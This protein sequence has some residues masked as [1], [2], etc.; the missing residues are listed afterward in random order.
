MNLAAVTIGR[1]VNAARR[2]RANAYAPYSRFAVGAAALAADGRIFSG[3][4]VENA[5]FG[6]T[7]CA[8]RNALA[9]MVAAGQRP[10]A[11]AIVTADGRATPCGACRQVLAE[12]APDLPII[13]ASE[14]GDGITVHR[15]TELLPAFFRFPPGGEASQE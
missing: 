15:L 8:E 10:V 1:L 6:L 4:N 2:A 3:C 7:I 11:M 12:F 13:L 5:S 14:T 9:A